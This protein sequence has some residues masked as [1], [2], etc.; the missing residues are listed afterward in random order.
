MYCIHCGKNLPDSA[1]FCI[2][3]GKRAFRSDVAN[4]TK[5]QEGTAT[6]VQ[7]TVQRVAHGQQSLVSS[8]EGQSGSYKWA[9]VYGWFVMAAAAYLLLT[10]V[11]TLL[12]GQDLTPSSAPSHSQ[13]PMGAVGALFQGLL[14]LATGLAILRRKLVAIRLVWA[15]V[16][17]AG[18]G[19]L[20]RGIAPLDLLIWILSAGMAKWFS[21]KR[22]FLSK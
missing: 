13:H 17:L 21:S 19:V 1:V 2:E 20:F 3:C 7:P 11:L 6:P 16:I 12:G 15:V 10:G 9:L 18:V 5:S 4:P 8:T 22:P 14:W